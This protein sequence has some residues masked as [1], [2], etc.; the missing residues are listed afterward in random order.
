MIKNPILPGFN[1]DPCIIAH[2]E[3]FYIATSTFEWAPGI[4]IYHSKNLK[5]WK[6]INHCLKREEQLDLKGLGSALG[7][8]A[9]ALSYNK[10]NQTFYMCYSVVHGADNN[11]FDVDNYMVTTKDILGEWS[12][13]IYLN[14][15]GFDPSLFHDTDGKSYVINLEWDFR[16]GYE[17]PGCIVLE[18]IDLISNQ[19]LG[20]P[21]EI[22]R[23][24]TD[25]G[26]LE[27]PFL[28]K[29]GK[30]YYLVTAEGGTGFGHG[31]VISR[32]ESI[33]GPY[34]CPLKK[35][36]VTS[37]PRDFNERGIGN[38]AKPHLYNQASILQKS[39]HG[40][41]VETQNAEVYLTHLCSR[42][43]KS[44][45][46][47]VLGRET[48]I[49]K[50]KWLEDGWLILD[51]IENKDIKRLEQV[52]NGEF[53]LDNLAKESIKEPQILED[54]STSDIVKTSTLEEG[55]EIQVYEANFL[56]TLRE[57]IDESWCVIEKDIK[58]EDNE[59]VIRMR[60]RDSLFSTY[61][62]SLLGKRITDFNYE[63]EVTLEYSP[64]QFTQM[65][66]LTCFYNNKNWY[67]VRLYWS[68]TYQSPCI[69][70]MSADH[71]LKKEYLES[72]V[73]VKTGEKICL[74]ACMNDGELRFYYT[75]VDE[76][77]KREEKAI[78]PVLDASILSDEYAEGFTGSFVGVTVTDMYKKSKWAKFS[79]FKIR[80]PIL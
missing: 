7:V 69:G 21:I 60:G 70:I 33:K 41:I 30:Y 20:N 32:S 68:K 22:S 5:D 57:A 35:P 56:Y 45:I 14:S 52:L 77:E 27:G 59:E 13:P 17:H 47:S 46:R 8:W 40:L 67:Y 66:G 18:E 28:Y 16:E 58:N 62:Q 65:A 6:L 34:D 72:R 53:I 10:I 39:G 15:S 23:G 11:N 38:S 3:D 80:Y 63:A 54:K 31:V 29:K 43:L 75:I 42:P 4:A 61:N 51:S 44:S 26:C 76:N 1:P 74:K 19:M 24:G 48:A 25:R 37:Q 9:P 36:V 2:G 78:G 50:M 12:N 79:N 71:G 64:E 49:Q 55:I 73:P